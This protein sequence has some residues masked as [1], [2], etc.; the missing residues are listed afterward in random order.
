M[1]VRTI[2]VQGKVYVRTFEFVKLSGTSLRTYRI[3][4]LS[5]HKSPAS[6]SRNVRTRLFEIISKGGKIRYHDHNLTPHPVI[7]FI[8]WTREV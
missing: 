7:I 4:R 5:G 6:T 2:R 3:S 1:Y 8:G